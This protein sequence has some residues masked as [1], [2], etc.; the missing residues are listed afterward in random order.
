MALVKARD[1]GKEGT[2]PSGAPMSQFKDYDLD[3][4]N[5]PMEARP[6]VGGNHLG[7]AWIHTEEF[8][9]GSFL[10]HSASIF[11]SMVNDGISVQSLNNEK[12]MSLSHLQKP[13]IHH[14]FIYIYIHV[15][16][17]ER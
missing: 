15:N 16:S 6:R 12:N 8:F 3:S 4:L 11:V 10:S 14:V 5:M 7:K 9:W 17:Y 2:V 13:L 1:G